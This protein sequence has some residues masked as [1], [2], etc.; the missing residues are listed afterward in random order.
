[1]RKRRTK[2]TIVVLLSVVLLLAIFAG[3]T[4]NA[5]SQSEKVDE[6]DNKTADETE[7]KNEESSKDQEATKYL[8]GD[9]IQEIDILTID[10]GLEV[11]FAESAIIDLWES[12]TGVHVNW[13]LPAG[14][15]YATVFQTRI[16]AGG[17]VPDLFYIQNDGMELASDGALANLTA[18]G[19][20][21]LMPNYM[22]ILD[23]YELKGSLTAPDGNMYIFPNM[24]N[25]PGQKNVY[26][27]DI[28][29]DWLET[30]GMEEPEDWDEFKAYLEAVRDN[31]M[32]GNGDS[33]DEVPLTSLWLGADVVNVFMTAYDLHFKDSQ[34]YYP[35][36]NGTIVCEWISDNFKNC[37]KL[38]KEYYDEGLLTQSFASADGSER[39]AQILNN[40]VGAFVT[41]NYNAHNSVNISLSESQGDEDAIFFPMIPL[42][43][44]VS[45]EPQGRGGN[46]SGTWIDYTYGI[47]SISDKVELVMQWVDYTAYS[48]EGIMLNA[49]GIEGETFEYVDGVPTL[50]DSIV[51]SSNG[52]NYEMR[53]RGFYH[54]NMPYVWPEVHHL[55]VLKSFPE[56]LAQRATDI[57]DN[58]SSKTPNFPTVL[59]TAE[60][61]E[62]LSEANGDLETYKD[63]MILK[64]IVGDVDIDAEWD[65]YVTT[66]KGLG[67]D[68]V[69]A[70]KQALYDRAVN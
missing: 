36:E 65:T 3:C 51:N 10:N 19:I 31:D 68:E 16:V 41:V 8:F 57:V 6:S 9:E 18:F 1:M 45:G 32:N 61:A 27:V 12:V 2:K 69:T 35:D 46:C 50:L 48:E 15:D 40:Q 44:Y 5:D 56:A 20:E 62:I 42:K 24:I 53:S 25:S 52:K 22:S 23:K 63:E 4:D 30:L 70:V 43:S 64:F 28:R 60:E 54:T 66:M 14:S 7:S 59:A 33:S 47:S 55:N 29:L 11:S 21:S 37:L 13:D 58:Y 39:T 26:S 38:V 17:D 34:G 49:F 67:I